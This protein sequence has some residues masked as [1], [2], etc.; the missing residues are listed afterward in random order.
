MPIDSM[1]MFRPPSDTSQSIMVL[2]LC[3][4]SAMANR[5][6]VMAVHLRRRVEQ[7][8]TP[9]LQSNKAAFIK[10]TGDGFL[11]TFPDIDCAARAAKTILAALD[12]RN[13]RTV[14]P[15]IYVRIALHYGKT[16]TVLDAGQLEVY[17][18]DV[19]IAFRL[20]QLQRDG[21]PSCEAPFPE[22]NRILCSERFVAE[23]RRH[24]MSS[25]LQFLFCGSAQLRS[26]KDPIDVFWMK[27]TSDGPVD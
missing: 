8:S 10:N 21:I 17:G 16:Y 5:D 6:E 15:P 3:E 9:M 20:E 1:V 19:N 2:D 13:R 12:K 23:L 22:V 24:E 4:S 7:L 11:A 25:D 27:T 26:I 14:N 18:N